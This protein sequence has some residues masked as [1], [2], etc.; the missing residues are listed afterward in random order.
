MSC[1]GTVSSL[2]AIFL[3]SLFYALCYQTTIIAYVL[4]VLIAFIGMMVDSFLGSLV[5]R[6][7]LCCKCGMITEKKIHCGTRA[8]L[9]SGIGFVGNTS[10]NSRSNMIT[11]ISA[12]VVAGFFKI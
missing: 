2:L 7:Y 9:Y 11:F 1:I 6:K 4:V 3:I 8:Q 5:Q 10:V 12:I